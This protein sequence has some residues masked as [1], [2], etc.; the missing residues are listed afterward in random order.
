MTSAASAPTISVM[1]PWTSACGRFSEN[2]VMPAATWVEV[3]RLYRTE[4]KLEIEVE[5]VLQPKPSRR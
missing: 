2:V 3:R 4:A 1:F 5:L